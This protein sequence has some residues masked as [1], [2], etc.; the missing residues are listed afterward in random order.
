MRVYNTLTGRKEELVTLEPHKVKIYVC[1]P[2]TYNYIHLGNARPLVVFDT[3]RRYLTYI[4]YD[5]TYVQNFTDVDDKIIKRSLEEEVDP[6]TL[7]ANYINEYFQD[8]DTLNILRADVHPQV[9]QHIREIIEAI[10]KLIAKGFAYMIDGD[11]YYRVKSFKEY[12]KLSGRSLED[13]LAGAR[14]EVDERKEEPV[15]FALWKRAK[16]GEPYWESPWGKGRPGWH[17]ECSVMANKYLGDT[18]DIHGGGNDLIFPHHENEIAQAEALTGKTFV[19]YWMHNGFIT[20]NNEKMS[21]SLGNFFLLR[22]VLAKFPAN[23][24]RFYLIATHYRSPLDFDDSKLEEA[25]KALGRL[26]T[27][28][29]LSD[30]FKRG[31]YNE[32]LKLTGKAARFYEEVTAAK[33]DFIAALEDDFNTARALGSLFA[34]SHR[35][36][37]YLAS[38]QA[39]NPLDQLA[40]TQTTAIFRELGD[41]LGIFF[42]KEGYESTGVN[43]VLDILAGL[44][45]DARQEKNYQLA[46]DIRDFL[47]N[48]GIT[49]E[50]TIDGT[51]YRY[52][53]PPE[54]AL[55]VEKLIMLRSSFKQKKQYDKADYIRDSLQEAGIGL[56]DTREGVRWKIAK[57]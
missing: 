27:T 31:G 18:I 10:S 4:G 9:S 45:R 19:N 15:D 49:S 57:V 24:V 39:D 33:Q 51:R 34:I 8:A 56:E 48:L 14:I 41:I 5:V 55:L 11:V 37:N 7:A 3:L 1:G 44:R 32:E 6:L 16:P 25:R 40:V 21:K 2:T 17:I 54:L 23:V 30:E 20:V 50:D 53:Y 38:A 28:L 47:A 43:N 26:Q 22:D 35:I 29:L 12:G 46:D 13:L 52:E 42:G 36:N